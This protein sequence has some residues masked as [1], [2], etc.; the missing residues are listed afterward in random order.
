MWF[1]VWDK[2]N[3]LERETVLLVVTPP[4]RYII[5]TGIESEAE[6]SLVRRIEECWIS[7]GG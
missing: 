1:C 2:Y 4:V 7:R 5:Q 3:R 6:K